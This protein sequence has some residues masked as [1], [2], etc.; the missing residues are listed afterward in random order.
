MGRPK[1]PNKKNVYYNKSRDNWYCYVE[2]HDLEKGKIVRK[3]KYFNTEIKAT[4]FSE[5][6]KYQQENPIYIE[7]NGI[8]L[9]ELMKN[10][11][12]TKFKSNVISEAQFLRINATIDTI[13]KSAFSHKNIHEITSEDIQ[14]YFY[15][16]ASHYHNSSLQKIFSEFNQAFQYAMNKGYLVSNPMI[17]V[18]KPKSVMK[19]KKV[20]ALTIEEQEKLSN[21]LL[22]TPLLL[23]NHK[24]VYLI[25]MYMGLRV[26]EALAL[27]TSDI[28]LH[29][30][31]MKIDKTLTK[32]IHGK[33]YMS[34]STK[35]VSGER[36][37]PIPKFLK[38]H[39]IE[40]I[41]DS[42]ENENF[43]DLLFVSKKNNFYVSRNDVNRHLK[44]L[45]KKL[46]IQEIS[47]HVLRHTYGT[48]CIES[49]MAPVAV[50]HLMGHKQISTTLDTYTSVLN[51]FKEQE[52]EKVNQY[53]LNNNLATH[54]I[55]IL[56]E[57][58]PI[59]IE[60]ER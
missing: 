24:N 16:L 41:Q 53:Y 11:A 2:E 48:R 36:V 18:I 23:D 6:I 38:P 56:D 60:I 47:S 12:I 58:A 37:L 30:N 13:S 51:R 46:G 21:Y 7:H 55:E 54:N 49:G 10:R 43:E 4:Q 42:K 8:P 27:K 26:G 25:Q 3:K 57:H 35:T 31:L 9:V 34:D 50:Q 5:S 22:N 39:I 44:L 52:V 19:D 32:D 29:N 14:E 40:Q 59:D 33:I 1:D 15:A 17:D 28:D 45:C 20:E